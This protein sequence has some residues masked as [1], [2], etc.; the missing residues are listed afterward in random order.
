MSALLLE[1]ILNREINKLN[2]RIDGKIIKGKSYK[3]DSL[4]HRILLEKL[5]KINGPKHRKISIASLLT[6]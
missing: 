2:E 3:R 6:T 5:Q 1:S 4:T